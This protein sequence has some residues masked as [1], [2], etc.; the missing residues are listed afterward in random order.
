MDAFYSHGKLLL[1]GEYLVLDGALAL[2]VPCKLGQSLT[3]RSISEK[4]IEWK[5]T[6]PDNKSWYDFT[7][8]FEDL[9]AV[10]PLDQ[11]KDDY[12]LLSAFRHIYMLK[13][14]LFKSHGFQ[15]LSHLE[16]PKDWGL[17]SSSTLINNLAQWAQVNPFDLNDMVFG[18]S[19]YDIACASAQGP[20]FYRRTNSEITILPVPFLPTFHDQ[21]WFVHLNKKQNSR[22]AISR[23]KLKKPIAL[24]KI[25]AVDEIA[26]QLSSCQS[27][28]DFC[29]LMD[30][31]ESLISSILEIPKISETMFPDFSGAIKS[32]G[33]WG[34]DY[35]LATGSKAEIHNYFKPKGFRTIK[36]YQDLIKI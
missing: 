19:G 31:H 16:F 5:S 35:I 27:I 7:I 36:A 24:S 20:V 34:G 3:V 1:T 30:R 23:Y 28:E 10:A 6:T 15:M 33:G 32:L 25:E 13:P 22:E 2:A 14:E 11:T 29:L 12:H 21:I 8:H 4:I 9:S 26:H 18:G 17:G